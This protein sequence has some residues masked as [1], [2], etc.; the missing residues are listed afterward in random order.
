MPESITPRKFLPALPLDIPKH[1]LPGDQVTSSI[2]NA[3][4]VLVPSNEGFYI[5]TLKS[6]LPAMTDENLRKRCMEFIHQEAQHGVAHKRYWANLDAQGYKFRGFEKMV[7]KLTFRTLEKL[8]P[9][10]MLLSLVSCVEH[11]NAFVGHEFLSQRILENADP[12]VRN[13]MEWHFAE[14]VEHR[15]VAFDLLVSRAPSYGARVMGVALTAPL[16][17]LLM[18]GLAASFLAQDKILF[19]RA[20]LSQL[21]N[22]LFGGHHLFKRTLGHFRDY[23][24]PSFHPSQMGSDALAQAVLSQQQSSVPAVI[25]PTQRA[26]AGLLAELPA[27]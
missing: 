19:R 1:W 7:D 23:L 2:L 10:W 17:Y 12:R 24:R 8:L 15:A 16:F 9:T 5:R 26:Q 14:E 13:L 6:C 3:Y 21:R 27:V 20:T 18:G 25:E 4:T 11:I 22:H